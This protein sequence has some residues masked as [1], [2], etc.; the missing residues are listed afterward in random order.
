MFE[1]S[2]ITTTAAK[3]SGSKRLKALLEIYCDN[4]FSIFSETSVRC[5]F[6][7]SLILDIREKDNKIL[8]VF[9]GG[10]SNEAH[11]STGK[12]FLSRISRKPSWVFKRGHERTLVKTRRELL[13]KF[14]KQLPGT[15]PEATSGE[16][17]I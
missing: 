8:E 10:V 5:F 17:S 7:D 6:K 15:I 3:Q 16:G 1:V 13:G 14:P 2:E 12:S 11:E 9:H 4:S